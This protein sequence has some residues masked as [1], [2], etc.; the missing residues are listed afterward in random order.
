MEQQLRERL[1]PDEHLL[2][3]GS[4][5]PFETLDKTNKRPIIVGTIIKAIVAV[6]VLILYFVSIRQEG[7]SARP[8]LIIVV[9]ALAAFA[10]LNP[11]LTARRLRKK[12]IYGLTDKRAMRCG[13]N[14]NAVPYERI[15]SAELR[16]DED[17]H[18]TLLC[19]PRAL[20]LKPRQWRASGRRL[21]QHG[22]RGGGRPRDVLRAAH[23]RRGQGHHEKV[24]PDQVTEGMWRASGRGVRSPR[25]LGCFWWGVEGRCQR[26]GGKRYVFGDG[27]IVY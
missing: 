18:T 10:M 4:P 20:K 3:C 12:T 9:L 16:T 15:K 13:S 1:M 21:H 7:V 11:F 23:G 27:R 26:P 24:P 6:C 8:G 5:E 2:W 19:G 14:D 22:G 17:G 25:P